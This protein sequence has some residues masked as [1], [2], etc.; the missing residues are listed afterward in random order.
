MQISLISFM[1]MA[2][3]FLFPPLQPFVA[4]FIMTM[5]AMTVIVVMMVVMNLRGLRLGA[6]AG[7]KIGLRDLHTKY[8]KP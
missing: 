5:M 2:C 3:C 1:T 8:A 4:F 6:R 7:K